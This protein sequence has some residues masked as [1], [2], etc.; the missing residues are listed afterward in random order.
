LAARGVLDAL[1]LEADLGA[2]LPFPVHGGH[3]FGDP[4]TALRLRVPTAGLLGPS[5]PAREPALTAPDPLALPDPRRALSMFEAVLRD[6][7][8]AEPPHAPGTG[9]GRGGTG[10]DT[11]SGTGAGTDTGTGTDPGT[12]GARAV[13][14][15]E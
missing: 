12:G 5:P 13:K 14:G 4:L 9:R 11:G 1:D 8:A 2:R 7:A 3:R 15:A 10:T 6:L